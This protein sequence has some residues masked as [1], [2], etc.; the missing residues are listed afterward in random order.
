MAMRVL[1][2]LRTFYCAGTIVTAVLIAAAGA[3][4]G[5]TASVSPA[6]PKLT[7]QGPADI[8]LA[9][10][11]LRDS[12]GRLCFDVEAAAR[13]HVVAPDLFDHVVSIKNNCSRPLKLKA[14][15]YGSERCNLVELQ[16][17][18]RADTILGTMRNIRFFRYV[19]R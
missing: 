7:P 6:V 12:L 11:L 8:S 15:Y 13:A 2:P 14:C 1:P 10:P 16:P 17:Y 4:Q 19:I 18:K 9:S 5:Q 3:A